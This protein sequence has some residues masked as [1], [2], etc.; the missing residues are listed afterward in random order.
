[1]A[2]SIRIPFDESGTTFSS[3]EELVY[4]IYREYN[5]KDHNQIIDKLLEGE[6]IFNNYLRQ[7][8]ENYATVQVSYRTKMRESDSYRVEPVSE[9][10]SNSAKIFP[11]GLRKTTVDRESF[12]QAIEARHSKEARQ[13]LENIKHMDRVNEGVHFS[14]IGQPHAFASPY[15]AMAYDP[16]TSAT[17]IERNVIH[18]SGQKGLGYTYDSYRS[19][20][21]AIDGGEGHRSEEI[22]DNVR[23]LMGEDRSKVLN[24]DRAPLDASTYPQGDGS[25]YMYREADLKNGG[26][27]HHAETKAADNVL[28]FKEEVRRCVSTT[29]TCGRAVPELV[30]ECL[31]ARECKDDALSKLK[32]YFEIDID[33]NKLNDCLT[34]QF[35]N[36]CFLNQI[37]K[38]A[39]QRI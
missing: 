31:K 15:V 8:K 34:K 29:K 35:L 37:C 30:K 2:K 23:L 27:G 16:L 12:Y 10:K 28:Y 26:K 38:E 18:V 33:S 22:S 4:R 19:R 32:E 5:I 1:M 13:N 9:N 39:A 20:V 7:V 11:G 3:A 25:R 17:S 14:L 6:V 36:K 21:G 24:E